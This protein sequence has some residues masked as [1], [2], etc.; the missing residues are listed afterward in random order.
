MHLILSSLNLKGA[1][2]TGCS[3]LLYIYFSGKKIIKKIA[4]RR[5]TC[6]YKT[7]NI[8]RVLKVDT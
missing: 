6:V 1:F 7:V 2:P 4:V 3:L 8:P 5:L